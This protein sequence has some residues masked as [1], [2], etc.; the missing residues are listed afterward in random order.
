[1]I[2]LKNLKNKSDMNKKLENILENKYTL[3]QKA[4]DA[5]ARFGGSWAF[6]GIFSFALG[7]WITYNILAIKPFD[8]YPFI[9]LNLM[10]SCLA[11]MQAP[12]IMMS[13]NRQSEIDRKRAE[14]DLEV[15]METIKIVNE[16]K[17]LLKEKKENE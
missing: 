2:I 11:A 4:A 8:P 10:L 13:N 1:M 5:I 7:A 3:G 6:I 16:L 17:Q 9:L 12:V 15:D 14:K